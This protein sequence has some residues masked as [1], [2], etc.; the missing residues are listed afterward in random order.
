MDKMDNK[1]ELDT[2]G[3]LWLGEEDRDYV[4]CEW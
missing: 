3:C 2:T 4:L 1:F